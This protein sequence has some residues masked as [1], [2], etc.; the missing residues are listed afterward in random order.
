MCG[1]S[2]LDSNKLCGVNENGF[3]EFTPDAINA[4]CDALTKG[5]GLGRRNAPSAVLINVHLSK[6]VTETT[7]SKTSQEK[8]KLRRKKRNFAKPKQNFPGTQGK[9]RTGGKAAET[10]QGNDGGSG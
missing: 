1:A 4:I 6:C 2:Q 8:A 9:L 5:G 7:D 10:T 3:G